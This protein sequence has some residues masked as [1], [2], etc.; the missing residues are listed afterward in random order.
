VI[1]R[2][3]Q[4]SNDPFYRFWSKDQGKVAFAKFETGTTSITGTAVS[5]M[6]VDINVEDAPILA[7]QVYSYSIRDAQSQYAGDANLYIG[8][9][10]GSQITH[11]LTITPGT[12]LPHNFLLNLRQPPLS[13]NGT[14]NFQ[15]IFEFA[16]G[17]G[18][19]ASYEFD[20]IGVEGAVIYLP[21]IMKHH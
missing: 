18:Y 10:E 16:P 12:S 6:L 4:P 11:L 13:W 17:N 19:S 2:G 8:V 20:W 5:P 7:G 9:R 3:Y 14:H 21:I 15:I 1:L